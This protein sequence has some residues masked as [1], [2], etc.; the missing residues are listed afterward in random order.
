MYAYNGRHFQAAI[1]VREQL[2]AAFQV[3][4]HYRTG[5]FR[6]IDLQYDQIRSASENPICDRQYLMRVRTMD[7]AFLRK[8]LRFVDALLA[9][10]DSLRL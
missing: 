3:F 2:R 9:G 10:G 4:I 5:Q 8:G 6:Q 7:E 1:N